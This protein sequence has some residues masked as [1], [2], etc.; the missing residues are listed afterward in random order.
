MGRAG[1]LNAECRSCGSHAVV[2]NDGSRGAAVGD[3]CPPQLGA[4]KPTYYHGGCAGLNIGDLILPPA[5]TG[6]LSPTAIAG[7]SDPNLVYASVR[8]DEA[9][10]YGALVVGDLYEVALRPPVL[11][12][13]VGGTQ[14]FTAPEGLVLQVV[15]RG[16][17]LEDAMAVMKDELA[18]IEASA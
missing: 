5:V 1:G 6:H 14:I 2:D 15:R 11:P 18:R 7:I 13:T 9:T 3:F 8:G 17:P 16:I 12:E 10:A 4:G